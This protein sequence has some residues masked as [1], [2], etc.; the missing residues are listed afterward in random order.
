MISCRLGGKHAKEC[1]M[2]KTLKLLG[3]VTLSVIIGISFTGCPN[4]GNGGGGGGDDTRGTGNMASV[5]SALRGTWVGDAGNGTLEITA[6]N[7]SGQ[8]GTSAY[9]VAG[10][11]DTLIVWAQIQGLRLSFSASGGNITASAQG[12]DSEVIFTYEIVG[13][14]LTIK[15][16]DG[17][18]IFVGTRQ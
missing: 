9:D 3:I 17:D 1:F 12:G 2:K 14:T 13:S 11:I 7:I 4:D 16:D 18:V 8:L 15:D 6:N 10:T 5:D